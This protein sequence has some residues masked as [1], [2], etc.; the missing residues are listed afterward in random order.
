MHISY[1]CYDVDD[2][3]LHLSTKII[4]INLKTGKKEAVSSDKFTKVRLDKENWAYT[5]NSFIEFGDFGPR[6]LNGFKQ[7]VIE[8]I[9]NKR[10]AP[11]WFKFIETLTNGNLFALIT[12]R[13]HSILS[14]RMGIEWII[15][16]YLTDEQKETMYNNLK[17]YVALFGDWSNSD[18]LP[19]IINYN[20]FSKNELVSAYLDNCGFYG[21]SSP[22]FI[23]EH[24]NTG[25]ESPEIGKEIALKEFISKVQKMAKSIGATTSFG[26]SDDD[27]K[28]VLHIEKVFKELRKIYP[29][30][31]FR[32]YDTSDKGYKK[33][34]I[35]ESL[36]IKKYAN[37]VKESD[38]QTPGLQSSILQYTQFGNMTGRLNPTEQDQRQDDYAN[39]FKRQTKYLAK[40]SKDILGKRKKKRFK[41]ISE[42]VIEFS[43]LYDLEGRLLNEVS[44]KGK[45]L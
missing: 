5:K 12:T 35:E 3:L 25:I 21:V 4:M 22:E 10:F 38:Q 18:K 36:R 33:I 7:D 17:K 44:M 45:I 20:N 1:S 28:N 14:F 43:Q 42:S 34:N 27:I 8:S 37:F 23:K 31:L 39:Q 11:S 16:N 19:R 26:M 6:G 30:T 40:T 24:K 41:K 29:D 9:Y 2:N 32:L 15:D 13:G